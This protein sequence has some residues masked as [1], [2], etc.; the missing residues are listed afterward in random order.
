MKKMNIR[1]PKFGFRKFTE[2]LKFVLRAIVFA[3]ILVNLNKIGTILIAVFDWCTKVDLGYKWVINMAVGAVVVGIISLI[4]R[5]NRELF[6]VAL[7]IGKVIV[8]FLIV[9]CAEC[10]LWHWEEVSQMLVAP[11]NTSDIVVAVL[12][13]VAAT[14]SFVWHLRGVDYD[15]DYYEEEGEEKD[16]ERDDRERK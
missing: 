12:G 4:T 16:Y 5:K 3:V 6:G 11:I 9:L 14:I 1:I 7:K 15:D 13:L 8:F 10:I 2:T